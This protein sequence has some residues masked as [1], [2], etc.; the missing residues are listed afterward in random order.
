MRNDFTTRHGIMEKYRHTVISAQDA[1]ERSYTI[2][3]QFDLIVLSERQYKSP[4]YII[5]YII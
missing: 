2:D 5:A 4:L 1:A 3:I